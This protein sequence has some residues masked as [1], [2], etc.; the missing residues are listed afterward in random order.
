MNAKNLIAPVVLSIASILILIIRW[1]VTRIELA[2]IAAVAYIAAWIWLI[3][4]TENDN[5]IQL[6]PNALFFIVACL[7]GFATESLT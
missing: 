6:L 5:D 2:I 3:K 7:I 4:A 1:P